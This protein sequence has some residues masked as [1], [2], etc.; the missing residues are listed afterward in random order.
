M[1]TSIA[2]E[3]EAISLRR[4]QRFENSANSERSIEGRITLHWCAGAMDFGSRNLTAAEL[5]NVANLEA[6]NMDHDIDAAHMEFNTDQ[7]AVERNGIPV[8]NQ[9]A[10]ERSGSLVQSVGSTNAVATEDDACST[11]LGAVVSN[12]H[13]GDGYK[14]PDRGIN[15]PYCGSIYE[16]ECDASLQ[17]SLGMVFDTW[18]QGEAFYKNYAHHVGFSVRKASHHKG[19]GGVLVWKRFFCSRQGWR[20]Q[21]EIMDEQCKKRKRKVNFTRCGCEAMIGFKRREDGKYVVARFI[22]SHTHQLASPGKTHLLR[23][24]REVSSEVRSKL[25]TCH[26]ALIGTS[27]AFRLLSEE[28]GGHENVGCTMRDLQNY[29][30][31]CKGIISRGDGQILIEIMQ[32]KKRLN[33]SFFFDYKLDDRNRL[34]HVFWADGTCRKNYSLFGDVVSFDSTYRSNRYGLVF[35]PFTGVNHHKSCITFGAAFI[36][37]EKIESYTWVFQTFLKAMGGVAPKLIITDEDLSMRAAIKEVFPGT[38]HRLCMWHILNKLPERVGRPLVQDDDFLREFMACVWDSETPDEFEARWASIISEF[39]LE[40]NSW[41]SDKY[42]MRKSWI[43]AYFIDFSLGGIL[44]TTSR[45]ESENAFFRHF[46]NRRLHLLEFWIRFQTALEEQRQ[47]ELLNDNATLHSEPMLETPWG[48]ERHARDVYTHTI[49]GI[50]QDEVLAARDKCDIQNMVQVGDERI[51]RI[52]DGSGKIREVRYNISTK[53]SQCSCKLFES[54]GILCCHIILV[55]KGAGCHEI[56]EHYLLNRWTKTATRNVVLDANGNALEG[57][58]TSLPPTMKKL[59]AETWSK[60]K[61]GMHAAKQCEENMK[62]FNKCI[63]DAVEHMLKVGPSS[64]RSKVQ[65]LES[66]V[67]TTFPDEINIHPPEVA[68]TKGNGRRIKRSSEQSSTNQRKKR[69]RGTKK[70]GDN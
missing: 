24:N 39:G 70:A 23:S 44:R 9:W 36:P 51:T 37:N 8:G 28:M 62:Y 66:F 57:S 58:C 64:E 68:H 42:K 40:D 47:K 49:F 34:T 55:L 14:T 3:E 6:S 56:P 30:R 7:W 63:S 52:S 21:K 67:G 15:L 53:V 4:G 12:E 17:P 29:D 45:S 1:S 50:F 43:P 2:G 11:F 19:D 10:V 69:S 13:E 59:Y 27:A 61:L 33:P 5:D 22:Q 20:K 60:I 16:P 26:K 32:D 65:E 38:I 18:Q 41:L 46:L 31:D 48:I 54:I 35:T 25:F